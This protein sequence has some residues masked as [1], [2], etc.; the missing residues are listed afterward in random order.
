MPIKIKTNIVPKSRYINKFI[1]L[2]THNLELF[3]KDGQDKLDRF[4][5]FFI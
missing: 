4:I 1:Y 2:E 3:L 5:M